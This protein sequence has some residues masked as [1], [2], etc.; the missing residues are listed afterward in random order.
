MIFNAPVW[1]IALLTL[2][3]LFGAAT[4]VQGRRL[5]QVKK[6]GINSKLNTYITRKLS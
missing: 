5:V 4:S 2:P 3:M 6:T 1:G